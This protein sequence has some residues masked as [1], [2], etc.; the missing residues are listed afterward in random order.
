MVFLCTVLLSLFTHAFAMSVSENPMVVIIPSYKNARFYKENLDSV[1]NQRYSN[2]KVVYV[3]DGDLLPD[4][5]GTGAFVE[6]YVTEKNQWHRFT[7]IR[8][9]DRQ[10]ALKNWYKAVLSCEDDETVVAL[11][12][13]D[14]LAHPDVL[15]RINEMY[16]KPGRD[17]WFTYGNYKFLSSG[18]VWDRTE[19]VPQDVVAKNGLRQWGNGAT[20]LK[21]FKA[22][23][24]KQIKIADLFYDDNFYR[25][26]PDIAMYTPMIEMAVKHYELTQEPLY[27]YN[28]MNILNEHRVDRNLQWLSDY[29]VRH[30]PSY[31][32]LETSKEGWITQKMQQGLLKADIVINAHDFEHVR[33]MLSQLHLLHNSGSVFVVDQT[34]SLCNDEQWNALKHDYPLCTFVKKNELQQAI[35][36]GFEFALILDDNY[37]LVDTE[38]HHALYWLEVTHAHAFYLSLHKHVIDE[39]KKQKNIAVPLVSV[40]L[41]HQ[42]APFVYGWKYRADCPELQTVKAVVCR[43]AD[44]HDGILTMPN[45]GVG[46]FDRE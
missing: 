5:D 22:W 32:P 42:D 38:L 25:M 37:H 29:H 3:A 4:S 14:T 15:A 16:H 45:G 27:V 46:L 30:K 20:H 34:D 19:A 40:S 36:G 7:L 9:E 39:L 11:D 17:V 23:L 8:N 44:M 41:N 28:D 18:V 33:G 43:K 21:T 2:Y 35:N 1:F 10:L 31:Q 13:D 12:G 24:F 26:A 6:K